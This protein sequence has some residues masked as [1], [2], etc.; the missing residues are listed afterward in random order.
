M[1][2]SSLLW[3]LSWPGKLHVVG[4]FDRGWRLKSGPFYHSESPLC[5]QGCSVLLW[6]QDHEALHVVGPGLAP[7]LLGGQHLDR[8]KKCRTW[9]IHDNIRWRPWSKQ[10]EG[11]KER[12]T[13]YHNWTYLG[14]SSY[15]CAQLSHTLVIQFRPD[16]GPDLHLSAQQGTLSSC[17][18]TYSL[19]SYWT[20]CMLWVSGSLPSLLDTLTVWHILHLFCGCLCMHVYFP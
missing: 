10:W 12:S 5:E 7:A 18:Q 11:R 16:R 2:I 15:L 4:A 17:P 1:L 9:K 8:D 19:V 14:Q 3:C 13:S 6:G 20:A